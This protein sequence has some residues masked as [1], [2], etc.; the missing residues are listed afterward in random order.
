MAAPQR[1]MTTS[2]MAEP[3]AS[4]T[5]KKALRDMPTMTVQTTIST[6]PQKTMT[7]FGPRFASNRPPT[8]ANTAAEMAPTTPKTPTC[9]IDQPS[10]PTA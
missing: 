3:S 9:V 5:P 4:G 2:G 10:T 1:Y 7:G 8:Q 6:T